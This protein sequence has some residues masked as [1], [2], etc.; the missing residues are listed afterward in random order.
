MGV[1]GGLRA[2]GD[3]PMRC[4]TLHGVWAHAIRL[5]AQDPRWK[6]VENRN[7]QVAKAVVNSVGDGWLA[8]RA[9]ANVGARPGM[10]ATVE[11]MR[12]LGQAA[13][14]ATGQQ[15]TLS[16][17]TSGGRTTGVEL[18]CDGT[19]RASAI[20]TSAIVAVCRVSPD[21]VPPDAEGVPWHVPGQW[22]I[23]LMDIH[24]LDP[25]IPNKSLAGLGARKVPP[26]LA[27]EVLLR[28][29]VTS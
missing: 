14:D 13:Q 21:L 16:R 29:G 1:G 12:A 15:V 28:A 9:G 7:E 27:A 6:T 18:R 2:G 3:G 19:L 5:A 17:V 20:W 8:I 11:A 4:L 22:G 26:R 25:V 10:P 23:R 24:A